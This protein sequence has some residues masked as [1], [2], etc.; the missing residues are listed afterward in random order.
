MK[1]TKLIALGAI[2]LTVVSCSQGQIK[3]KKV[4]T[5][6]I[7]SVSY[8]LGINMAQDLQKNVSELDI[9]VYIQGFLSVQ[10]TTT[11]SLI[12]PKEVKAFLTTYFK[13]KQAKKLEEQ[14]GPYKKANEAFLAENKTKEGVNTTPSGLQYIVLKEGNGEKP[15][16]DDTVEVHY[17]GTLTDGTVFDSS[18]DRG[19]P[20]EFGVGQVIKG[21]TEGLQL[22][23]IGSKYKFFIPQNLAYGERQAGRAIKPFST[24]IFEVELLDI[25][26]HDHKH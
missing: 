10:D 17:H 25:K 11:T 23:K 21:W 26:G 16:K 1:L 15:T 5:S 8:A 18:V 19:K 6:D 7:D 12:A 14:H 2:S 22:M 24:L 9:D 3:T 13:N 20:T 4:L